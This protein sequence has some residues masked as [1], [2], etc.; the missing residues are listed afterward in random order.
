MRYLKDNDMLECSLESSQKVRYNKFDREIDPVTVECKQKMFRPRD[1]LKKQGLPI[2]GVEKV[3]TS[4][5]KRWSDQDDSVLS[6][7]IKGLE[8]DSLIES[9]FCSEENVDW[10]KYRLDIEH[11]PCSE[12]SQEQYV[13]YQAEKKDDMSEQ[14]DQLS[15]VNDSGTD[16]S[17]ETVSDF[18]SVN[19]QIKNGE[20][21]DLDKELKRKQ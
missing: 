2:P 12:V 20:D 9:A 18:G 3:I 7:Q 19:D 4:L 21:R 1:E 5:R 11:P 17:E 13:I 10:E 16:M 15:D 8:I 6:E 14:H